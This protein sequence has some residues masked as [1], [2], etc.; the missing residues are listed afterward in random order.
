MATFLKEGFL[1]QKGGAFYSGKGGL[2]RI[3]T[4]NRTNSITN[5]LN[6]IT[7]TL[8]T[9]DTEDALLNSQQITDLKNSNNMSKD[10]QLKK[11][12]FP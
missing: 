11:I 4:I 9:T 6:S 10:K 8:D 3:E 7:N 12:L 1:N 5:S 2:S